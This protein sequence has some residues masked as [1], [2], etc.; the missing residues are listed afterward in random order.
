MLTARRLNL[1]AASHVHL[2]EPQWNPMVEEQAAARVH[3]IGQTKE[4]TVWR[5]IV[6]DSIEEV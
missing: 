1:T 6:Q 4:V 2:I 5:Y 3:R